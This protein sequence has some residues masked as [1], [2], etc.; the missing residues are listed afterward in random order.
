MEIKWSNV[1]AIGL[2][3]FAI[4]LL[5]KFGSQVGA[6][7]GNLSAIG[8]GHTLEEK[9]LGLGVLGLI[10]VALVAVVRIACRN[11]GKDGQ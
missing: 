6:V 4:V 8:P 2:A 11:N 10:L 3:F 7:L 1:V 9:T 5:V